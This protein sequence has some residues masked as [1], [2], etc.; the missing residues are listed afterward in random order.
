M[1]SSPVTATA[2][3]AVIAFMI[4]AAWIAWATVPHAATAVRASSASQTV[5]SA[6]ATSDSDT[7]GWG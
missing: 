3:L 1:K 2:G 4:L 5:T 7:W 6:T